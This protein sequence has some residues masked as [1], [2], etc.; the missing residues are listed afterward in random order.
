MLLDQR[1]GAAAVAAGDAVD[2]HAAVARPAR[3]ARFRAG[4]RAGRD[5]A[6][7]VSGKAASAASSADRARRLD[8][9]RGQRPLD[10][11]ARLADMA[12]EDDARV[13]SG[14]SAFDPLDAVRHPVVEQ[15]EAVED[16][17]DQIVE[18]DAGIGRAQAGRGTGRLP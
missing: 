16:G 5:G 4:R 3:P 6:A 10:D 8:D 18:T 7:A 17:R 11:R 15:D 14:P 9:A 13:E 12:V 1:V 2:E